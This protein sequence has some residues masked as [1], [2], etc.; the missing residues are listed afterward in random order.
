M[1]TTSETATTWMLA[2]LADTTVAGGDVTA[3]LTS[4]GETGRHFLGREME[5]EEDE[6]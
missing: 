5:M 1:L 2:M 4:V 6:K 3:V